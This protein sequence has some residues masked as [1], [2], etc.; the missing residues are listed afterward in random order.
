[1]SSDLEL[2]R[3]ESLGCQRCGLA[4]GRTNVVFGEGNPSA[5]LVL[6]GEGP[7]ETEDATG[8]PFVGRAG[9]LLDQALKQAGMSRKHV[10]ICN[11][12]KCRPTLTEGGR[13]R[14][15]AP[16]P[17]EIEACSDWLG[18][19]LRAISPL[20][21]VCLGAP[22]ANA[23]IHKG[24]RITAERGEWFTSQYARAIT[25]TFHPAYVLRQGGAAYEQGYGALM[26]DLLAA[27]HKV[28]ELRSEPVA[29]PAVEEE[30]LS[31]F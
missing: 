28:I 8:R 7:G 29:E 12:V 9:Q 19:Q 14:N 1:M 22:S 15:R 4:A 17:D 13:L 11:I 6:V 25:A 24:F 23:L 5:P 21:I 31:L 2:L 3:V 26:G 20:V 30:Q 27:R 18:R 16:A 10:Y